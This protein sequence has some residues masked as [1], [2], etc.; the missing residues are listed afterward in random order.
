MSDDPELAEALELTRDE[1]VNKLESGTPALEERVF[2]LGC[3]KQVGHYFWRPG[4]ERVRYG[5]PPPTPWGYA[6]DNKAFNTQ[7]WHIEKKDGWTAVGLED[8]TVDS[9]PGSHSIFAFCGDLTLEDAVD[10]ARVNFPEVFA[11]LGK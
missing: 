8:R 10:L 5:G 1:L 4:M 7:D 6:L 11:R 2:Y 9:R 3:W